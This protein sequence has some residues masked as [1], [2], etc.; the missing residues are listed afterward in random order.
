MT[1]LIPTAGTVLAIGLTSTQRSLMDL[2]TIAD[3]TV[4]RRILAVPG[5][6]QVSI[7]GRDVRA[8]QVHVRPDDLIRFG[9]GMNDVLAAARK[10]TGIRGAG[11]IDTVN[12]RI[13]LQTQGQ[14]LTSSQLARTVLR[15]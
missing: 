4:G 3:W 2:R 7:Y 14:S 1:P 6:A 13:T 10:A 12:Q 11:F 9:I 5:I 8:L 15:R